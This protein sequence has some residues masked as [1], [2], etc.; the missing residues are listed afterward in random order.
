MRREA[1]MP[2]ILEAYHQRDV[3]IKVTAIGALLAVILL[4]TLPSL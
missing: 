4:I 3:T 2:D 1:V